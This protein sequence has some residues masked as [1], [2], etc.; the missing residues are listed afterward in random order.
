[1]LP[2]LDAAVPGPAARGHGAVR[3]SR[4]RIRLRRALRE[5]ARAVD[6]PAWRAGP[7]LARG[8]ALALGVDMDGRSGRRRSRPD[9]RLPL[10]R[11]PGMDILRGRLPCRRRLP[12]DERQ[13]AGSLAYPV[14]AREHARRAGRPGRRDRGQ[15]ASGRGPCQPL[16]LRHPA[17]AVL[18]PC[19]RYQ[20][21]CRPLA[22][23]LFPPAVLHRDRC[24]QRHRRVGRAQGRPEPC[25]RGLLQPHDDARDGGLDP[26]LLAPRAQFPAGRRSV[27]RGIARHVF[28]RPQGRH[29]RHRGPA[30]EPGADRRPAADRHQCR[31]R[32]F[33]GPADS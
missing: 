15:S 31:Q 20:R 17:V 33:S 26:L 10:E 16:D 3:L 29:G 30:E 23:R 13:P 9:P 24:R 11:R 28:L 4:A 7:R 25:G 8:R 14:P 22:E 21:Q 27:H 12:P 2:P 19:A 32:R 18:R 6:G 5:G 1:M